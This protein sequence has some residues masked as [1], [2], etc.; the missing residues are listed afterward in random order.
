MLIPT[1]GALGK[2]RLTAPPG[3]GHDGLARALAQDTISAALGCPSV[4]H[5]V[6]VTGDEPLAGWAAPTCQ[7]LPDP[8]RGLLAA[9]AAGLET[10][11]PDALAAV[12]LG[13]LPALTAEDLS[14]ALTA[15]A[16][17]PLPAYVPDADG[18][19]TVLLIGE[20]STLRPAFGVKSAAR[21]ARYAVRLDLHLP[22][23]RR[24]VDDAGDLADAVALGVGT[25]T[26]AALYGRLGQLGP[27]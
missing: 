3:V 20:T 19:G 15:A 12:L 8:G 13:D 26:W 18:R 14:V 6:V 2:S 27:D 4:P 17:G 23:L 1:R 22:R 24:D 25:H 21:H 7:V 9:I 11:E 16:A 5:V 10:L